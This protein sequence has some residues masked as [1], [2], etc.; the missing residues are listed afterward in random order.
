MDECSRIDIMASIG[1]LDLS[2]ISGSQKNALALI[3]LNFDFTLL[4]WSAPKEYK[5][6]GEHL[7]PKR[8]EQA[9]DGFLHAVARKLTVLFFPQETDVPHVPFLIQAYGKRASAV[10]K[11]PKLNP[12]GTSVHG[13]FK[14]Y[15]GVDSTSIWAAA[16]S[17]P[18]A[19]Q[20]HLLACM[21]AYMFKGPEAISIWVELVEHRQNL[22]LARL[23]DNEYH[24]SELTAA[25]IRI[26]RNDL[27]M[28]D[29][30]AR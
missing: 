29:A 11:D 18:G 15:V 7:A 28:W 21:I 9:E 16:T 14:E 19:I 26:E 24:V 17:G 2:V 6:V 23:Q 5:E 1:D 25:K 10:S 3:S 27:A 12:K 20:M 22:L 4:K 13:P 8:K 30:S